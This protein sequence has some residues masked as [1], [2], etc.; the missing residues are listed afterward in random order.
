[1]TIDQFLLFWNT[2]IALY[3]PV[4][5]LFLLSRGLHE[6]VKSEENILVNVNEDKSQI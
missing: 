6:T 2:K 1:M 4:L 5:F 3:F